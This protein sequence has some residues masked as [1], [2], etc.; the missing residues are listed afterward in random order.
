MAATLNIVVRGQC[1][2][3]RRYRIRN[4]Q[5]HITVACPQCGRAIHIK[6]ED[7]K[8]AFAS[9]GV[10]PL[11]IDSVVPKEAIPIEYGEL[12]VARADAQPGFTGRT[13]LQHDEALLHRAMHGWIYTSGPPGGLSPS[14][15]TLAPDSNQFR[16]EL[17]ASFHFAGSWKN[18]LNLLLTA[19]ACAVP[20]LIV[21][22]PLIGLRFW[23]APLV[24][25]A[26][27]LHLAHFYWTVMRDAAA[28]ED[29]LGWAETDSHWLSDGIR[30]LAWMVFFL[31]LASLPAL[32][33]LMT[34]G[35]AH[36]LFWPWLIAAVVLGTL[37]WPV[38]MIT[39]ALGGTPEHLRPDWMWKC[40]RAMGTSYLLGWLTAVFTVAGA[41]AFRIAIDAL[42]ESIAGVIT[43]RI[44]QAALALPM[45]LLGFAV[46]L[47]FGYVH[48]RVLGLLFRH[49]GCRFPWPEVRN[50]Y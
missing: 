32:A 6:P 45:L 39:V 33:V 4:A 50:R 34:L 17:L 20:L 10:I 13:L 25:L 46:L 1:A 37:P 36:A 23:L 19:T 49:Y 38:L 47:Y 24:Y 18:G 5:A 44:G 12:K 31:G 35:P 21:M 7:V 27:G 9:R 26:V 11:K 42:G 48:F 14:T 8:L 29:E 40:M 30:A 41:V 15:G 16:R 3:G 22:L 43:T 28:G 2:C